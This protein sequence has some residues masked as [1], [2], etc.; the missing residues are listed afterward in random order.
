MLLVF[1]LA[2]TAAPAGLALMAM[3]LGSACFAVTQA[4]LVYLAAP[5]E[6]R[7]RALGVLSFCIGLGLLGF[8]H[9]GLMSAW[10]G[11][12]VATAVIGLEGLVALFLARRLW[13]RIA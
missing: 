12:P 10:L 6:M 9:V 5:G 2:P 8:L 11:A 4:T 7:S 1:A 3:G 13:P